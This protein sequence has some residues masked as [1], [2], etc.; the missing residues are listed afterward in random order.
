MIIGKYKISKEDKPFIVAEM[1]GNHNKSLDRAIKIVEAAAESGAHMLKLQTYTADTLTI[2]SKNSDFLISDSKSLWKGKTLYDLYKEACTPWEWHEKIFKRCNELGMLCFSTPFDETAVDFLEKLNVPAY[3]IA[4]FE[5]IHLPLIKKVAQTG[6]PVIISTGL[7]TETEI[8]EAVEALKIGGCKQFCLLKCTSAYPASPENS[9]ILTI[10]D[11][12]K[13][14]NCEV[15]LSD[16]TLGIGV[17]LAAISHGA[18]IIEK[19]FTLDRNDGGVDS[20]FSIEPNDMKILIKESVR[21]WQSLGNISYGPTDPEKGGLKLRR[22][23]YIVKNIESGQKLTKENLRIIRPG[24]G[25]APKYYE[26]LLGRKVNKN[27]EQGTA[28]TWNM[29]E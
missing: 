22:S 13:K 10:P 3:K 4:S 2:N 23:I 7:A 5:N 17:A 6:K 19:H 9:N 1:S 12:R 27:L 24:K 15:G 20:S 16:H 29:L 28:L 18:T 25:L 8:E 11:L 21:T 14:F 26:E